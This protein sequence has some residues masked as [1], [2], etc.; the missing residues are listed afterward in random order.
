MAERRIAEKTGRGVVCFISNYSW[1][2]G[3]SHTGMR[4]RYLE[5]FNQ[6]RTDN[7]HGDRII[8][9]YA[10]DG[11]TS[12][13]VFALRGQSPGIKIGTSIALLSKSEAAAS[14]LAG[15]RIQYRDFHQARADERRQA[16]LETLDAEDIDAGYSVLEPNV[17]L[18][19]PFKPMAVSEDWF[20][21]PALRDLFPASFPGVV[22]GRD[23]F[24]VDIDHDRL[25]ETDR[26]LLQPRPQP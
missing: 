17:R 19:L 23:P 8:S 10:P 21:S 9:E 22:T 13:T 12:E 25:R 5:A 7:L 3:L 26:R 15:R 18:G 24:L 2:D 1:L 20:D 14:S 16:L 4:E 6:I 11:R